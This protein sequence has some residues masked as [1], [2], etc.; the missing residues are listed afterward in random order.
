M[1]GVEEL[2]ED[3]EINLPY[4]LYNI[5]KNGLGIGMDQHHQFV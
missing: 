1:D 2:D 4:I 3:G 5:I